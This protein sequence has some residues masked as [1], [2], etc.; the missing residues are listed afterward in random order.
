MAVQRQP[1]TEKRLTTLDAL[2]SAGLVS[3]DESPSL[4]AVESQYAISVPAH[5]TGLIDPTDPHDP[6]A[7]QVI[8]DA[9]EEIV[10]PEENAD[11]IG[12]HAHSPVKG[13]VHRYPDRVLLKVHSACAVYCRFCFRREMVGPGGDSM[14]DAD[15][16]AAFDYISG[17]REIWEVILTGGDPFVLSSNRLDKILARIDA[18]GH[19]QV[20]R[21][22]TRVPVAE[23]TRIS[24]SLVRMLTNRRST[25]YVAVHCNHARELSEDA[26]SACAR[27]SSAGIPL[28]GQSVLLKGVNDNAATLDTL[29]RT[30]VTARITPY[31]LHH[32]D[33]APGTS[34]FRVSLAEGQALMDQLRG[35]LSGLALPTYMLDIPGGFGKVPAGS[36]YLTVDGEGQTQVT[37]V[38]GQVHPYPPLPSKTEA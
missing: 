18:I 5:F 3:K 22:H 21:F 12:D 24:D 4:R 20:V 17:H 15:L 38:N 31:Y 28:L 27:L 1:E 11:P 30:M 16:K 34:H 10:S 13:L 8:P 19:V 7:R 6:I 36:S 29:F 23:P 14:T 25:V 37:D 26:I 9:R 35:T 32:P 2:V 33:L